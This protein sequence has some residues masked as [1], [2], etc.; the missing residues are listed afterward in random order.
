[1]VHTNARQRM[2][3]PTV[4]R[5]DCPA[6]PPGPPH[7]RSATRGTGRPEPADQPAAPVRRKGS[8]TPRGA[9][10]EL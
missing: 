6:A 9:R 1:M 2:L 10:Q 3:T 8:E 7:L 4:Y 5:Q